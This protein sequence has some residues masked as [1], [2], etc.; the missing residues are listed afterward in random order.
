M[1]L[2]AYLQVLKNRKGKVLSWLLIFIAVAALMSFSQPL[3]YE[4]SSRIL[5]IQEGAAGDPYT[6]AKSNQYISSL[7]AEAVQSGSFFEMLSSSGQ[8]ID[9]SYFRGDYKQQLKTWKKTVEARSLSDTGVMEIK[10]YHPDTTQAYQISLAINN[11]IANQNSYYQSASN[12]VKIKVIDQP[13]I[14]SLPAKP[15][16]ALNFGAA[17]IFGFVFGLAYVYYFPESRRKT[18]RQEIRRPQPAAERHI[19][20][21]TKQAPHPAQGNFEDKPKFHG[22]IRN[23][24]R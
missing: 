13:T 19:A 12:N 5:I 7:L 22:N 8:N 15:D 9:R 11:L 3:K 16:L 17:I 24:I 6:I 4:A 23:V 10:V 14:S 20:H 18:L 21:E 2:N 1:E